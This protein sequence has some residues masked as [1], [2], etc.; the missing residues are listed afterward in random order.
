MRVC[1]ANVVPYSGIE[2]VLQGSNHMVRVFLVMVN[3]EERTNDFPLDRSRLL[4]APPHPSATLVSGSLLF[5][6]GWM[7]GRD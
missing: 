4:T 7:V 6:V 5:K 3:Q 2:V 1:G